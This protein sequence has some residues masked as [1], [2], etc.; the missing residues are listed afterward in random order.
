M[1]K[2]I[3]LERGKED[4]ELNTFIENKGICVITNKCKN[5]V[6]RSIK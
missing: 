5:K 6:K 1:K 2:N 3:K 4:A